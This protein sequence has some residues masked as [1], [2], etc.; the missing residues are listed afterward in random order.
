MSTLVKPTIAYRD[1]FLQGAHDFAQEGRLDSTY[2]IFLGYDLRSMQDQFVQF[3]HDL[4]GLGDEAR[5]QKGW[6]LDHVFWLIDGNEYIGQA[7]I[8]PELASPYLLTYGGH[9]GYSIRPSKRLKGYGREILAL[10]LE[11]A[12]KID[13]RRVLVTCDADNVGSRR[14][15]E[16]NGGQFESA[17]EM[18]RST[19]RAEGRTSGGRMEKLRY[20]ID[21]SDAPDGA[22]EETH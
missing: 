1:S 16:H 3:V 10:A 21:L 17:I 19:F 2:S 11:S 6:Y 13:L 20:W 18:T 22:R 4:R 8:R 7:S 12:R 14:I 9:I 5:R 15:I